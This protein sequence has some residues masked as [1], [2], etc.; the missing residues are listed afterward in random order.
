[1][2]GQSKETTV[3]TTTN[4]QVAD[5]AKQ[6]IALKKWN[7]VALWKWGQYY[8]M[9]DIDYHTSFASSPPLSLSHT[10]LPCH[11]HTPPPSPA[12]TYP[13][14]TLKSTLVPFVTI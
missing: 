3:D 12:P 9:I 2:S 14:Q 5:D 8:D 10:H 6:R 4:T 1:M 11:L 13:L 7:A